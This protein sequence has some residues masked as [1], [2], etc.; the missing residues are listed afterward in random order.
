MVTAVMLKH[1]ESVADRLVQALDLFGLNESSG[2][3]VDRRVEDIVVARDDHHRP[4]PGVDAGGDDVA[5]HG[6]R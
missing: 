4:Q 6:E 5:E 3:G 1:R 2:A